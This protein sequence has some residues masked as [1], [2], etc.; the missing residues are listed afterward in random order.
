MSGVF[1]LKQLCALANARHLPSANL[2]PG[3]HRQRNSHFR[4]AIASRVAEEAL[5]EVD[6]GVIGFWCHRSYNLGACPETAAKSAKCGTNSVIRKELVAQGQA[7]H[8]AIVGCADSR[9]PLET[10]FDTMP[11][12]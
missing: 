8:T 5:S 6:H 11:G 12:A 3:L 1:C 10:I 9:A 2:Q 7:P 4:T